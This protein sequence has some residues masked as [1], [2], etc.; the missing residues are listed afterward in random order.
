MRF[1]HPLIKQR[2]IIA[3]RILIPKASHLNPT[4]ISQHIF[5]LQPLQKPIPQRHFIHLLTL[6]IHTL[7]LMCLHISDDLFPLLCDE[8][9]VLFLGNFVLFCLHPVFQLLKCVRCQLLEFTTHLLL[10]L[11]VCVG[12]LLLCVEFVY[13]LLWVALHFEKT[14]V[15]WVFAYDWDELALEIFLLLKY[16]N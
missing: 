7:A 11:L 8:V 6:R 2:S 10:D 13:W 12:D 4:N 9:L 16:R 15:C 1:S 5:Q 14:F 3:L